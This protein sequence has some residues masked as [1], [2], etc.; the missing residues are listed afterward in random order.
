[1]ERFVLTMER[2]HNIRVEYNEMDKSMRQIARKTGF[3]R[4]TVSK[5]IHQTDFNPTP[6]KSRRRRSR[7]DAY[8]SLIRAWLVEDEEIPRKQRHTARRIYHRFILRWMEHDFLRWEA[9]GR[10]IRSLSPPRLV[11]YPWWNQLPSDPLKHA[12]IWTGRVA[13]FF[14]VTWINS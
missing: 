8:R 11:D 4:S 14:I 3:S 9:H 12:V 6:V 7:S 1:M 13:W 10:N 5:D 2:I